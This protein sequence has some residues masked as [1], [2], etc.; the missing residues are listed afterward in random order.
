MVGAVL[1]ALTLGLVTAVNPI[2]GIGAFAG[3]AALVAFARSGAVAVCTFTALTYGDIITE[4]TGPALSPLKLAGGALILLAAVSLALHRRRATSGIAG[5]PV[6]EL[7]A[8]Q[9]PGWRQHPLTVALVVGF[10]AWALSSAAWATDLAQ[11]KTLTMRLVTDALVFLAVPVFVRSTSHLRMLGWTALAG[12]TLSALYGMVAHANLAGRS[13]GTFTDPNEF[14][15]ALVPAMA[16]GL[17]LAE[18]S[19]S[20][21]ARWAGRFGVAIC[22][23]GV[24]ASGSRGGLLAMLVAFTLV[25]LGSRGRERVR[26]TGWTCMAIACGAAWLVLTPAGSMVAAR[27]SDH[28]SSGRAELWTVA[29]RELKSEPL[30]GVGLGNYPVVSKYF[31][32]GLANQD[33]FLRDARTTHSTPLELLAELGIVGITL[34]YAFIAACISAGIRATRL[35]RRLDDLRLAAAARGM[36]AGI[37]AAI[38]ATFFLSNQYQELTWVLCGA[39]IAAY[40]V[41]RRQ[42]ALVDARA[43]LEGDLVDEPG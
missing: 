10:V 4:Y 42:A 33:L 2:L 3:L 39:C 26:L 9:S 22:L 17:P 15:A 27:L 13:I 37:L 5:D 24:L 20:V 38:S 40:T 14:A 18:S 36:V 7:L 28:D 21:L 19:N 41:A 16:F 35:A 30:H 43:L 8:N 23:A 11:V 31:V 12:G 25:L 1:L 34:Y 32:D 29:V 6:A